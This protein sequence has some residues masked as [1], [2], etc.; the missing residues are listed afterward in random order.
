MYRANHVYLLL[1]SL[2]NVA[3]GCYWSGARAGWRGK[4]ALGG[5]WLLLLAPAVLLYAFF[6]EPP[7]GSPERG[8]TFIGVLLTL[9]GVVVQWPNRKSGTGS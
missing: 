2:V 3:L 9:V 6:A 4:L 7:R 5:S 8:F 1:A